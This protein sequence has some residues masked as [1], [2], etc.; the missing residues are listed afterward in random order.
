LSSDFVPTK[1][2][3]NFDEG[4]ARMPSPRKGTRARDAQ[5][6]FDVINPSGFSRR[7]TTFGNATGQRTTKRW[8]ILDSEGQKI[9]RAKFVFDK[10]GSTDG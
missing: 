6:K 9:L 7:S 8:Q 1:R 3:Q 2:W 4:N 10:K 5:G